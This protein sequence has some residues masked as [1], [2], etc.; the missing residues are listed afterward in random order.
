MVLEGIAV[1]L[2]SRRSHRR[3]ERRAEFQP[4]EHLHGGEKGEEARRD[5]RSRTRSRNAPAVLSLDT[6]RRNARV[7]R[8]GG[9]LSL[10]ERRDW[11]PFPVEGFACATG[12]RH[13]IIGLQKLSRVTL[14]NSKTTEQTNETEAVIFVITADLIGDAGDCRTGPV[15]SRK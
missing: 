15:A 2:V 12:L 9:N 10:D 14:Q 5:L 4:L 7:A 6:S 8:F 3:W 13:S 1:K 11:T